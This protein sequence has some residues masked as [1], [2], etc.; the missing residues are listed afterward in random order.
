MEV[1]WAILLMLCITLST[2]MS[3]SFLV[4]RNFYKY[5]SKPG[6]PKLTLIQ[7]GKKERLWNGHIQDN[8]SD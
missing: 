8:K 6:K 4:V 3:A 1:N 2:I 7:G 5:W